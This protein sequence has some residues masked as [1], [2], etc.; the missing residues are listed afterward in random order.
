MVATSS[1]AVGSGAPGGNV[2][3]VARAMTTTMAA[4]APGA[5]AAPG[6]QQHASVAAS[7]LAA[8]ATLSGYQGLVTAG[9]AIAGQRVVTVSTAALKGNS[10]NVVR[11]LQPRSFVSASGSHVRPMTPGG[12]NRPAVIVVQRTPGIG[13][14]PP[15]MQQLTTAANM[16]LQG[17]PPGNISTNPIAVYIDQKGSAAESMF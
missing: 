7:P 15:T 5:S 4:A 16:Q 11:T 14:G 13:G 6:S 9:A 17:T 10:P 1:G 3:R 8:A 12:S 2:M